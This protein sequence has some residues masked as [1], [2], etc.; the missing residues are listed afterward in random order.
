MNTFGQIMAFSIGS[1]C[2]GVTLT[3]AGIFALAGRHSEH[4]GGEGCFGFVLCATTLT[5]AAVFF[6]AALN[7]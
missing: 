5:L 3:L 7:S 6:F 1:V 4:K 2:L